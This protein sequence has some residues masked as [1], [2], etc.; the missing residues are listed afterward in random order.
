LIPSPHIDVQ[1]LPK[2]L[3]PISIL[4]Y[5]EHPSP[6][7][8]FPSSHSSVDFYIPSPQISGIALHLSDVVSLPPVQI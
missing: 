6:F 2:Q 4:H 5:L 3:Y 1:M 7:K 8:V